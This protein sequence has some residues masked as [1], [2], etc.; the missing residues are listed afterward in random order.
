MAEKTTTSKKTNTK[1]TTTKLKPSTSSNETSQKKTTT[2]TVKKST[3]KITTP[4]KQTTPQK[5]PTKT[6]TKKPT[7]TTTGITTTSMKTVSEKTSDKSPKTTSSEKSKTEIPQTKTFTTKKTNEVKTATTK[8]MAKKTTKKTVPKT[9]E[10]IQEEKERIEAYKKAGQISKKV[11]EFIK[12]KIK[13]GVKLLELVELAEK[14]IIEL[15]GK[16]GFPVNIS[17]NHIAAHYTPPPGD[18]SEIKEGDIVKFDHGVH[19]DGYG[20]DTA[21]TVSLN[22]DPSLKDI[23]KASEEAV[24]NAIKEIKHG[25]MT[26]VLGK[27]IEE[28]VRKYGYKPII[29][30]QGHK[31]ERWDVHAG[32]SI[33]CIGLPTGDVMEEGE[34]F[35]VE[36]FVSNGEGSIHAQQSNAQI[37]QLDPTTKKI[38]LRTK[39][40]RKILS[41]LV[42]EFKTLPFSRFQIFQEFPQGS[43]GILELLKTN[44]LEKHH[45]LSEKKGFF[46]AQTEHTI[47][48][49]KTG[50]QILT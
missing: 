1:K 27:V 32:K 42:R 19:I 30:L 13:P 41:F 22:N 23:V 18:E 43:F 5:T 2:K 17:I 35:A 34:I 37:F 10:Q 16:P 15:G 3:T 24:T 9:P 50:C 28:T 29:N 46:I 4:S 21:F 45:I 49:T 39:S 6:T 25:Q 48:V 31:I 14:K 26:N 11:K 40:S 20:V 12:P 33:P 7:P 44:K 36:V 47:L 38:P 8:T